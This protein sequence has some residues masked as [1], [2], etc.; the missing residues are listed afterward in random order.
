M[1]KVSILILLA[2]LASALK[3]NEVEIVFLILLI[4]LFISTVFLIRYI[5]RYL[6]RRQFEKNCEDIFTEDFYD[7]LKKL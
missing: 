4:L 5:Q 2:L 3:T 6:I 7:R 1:K